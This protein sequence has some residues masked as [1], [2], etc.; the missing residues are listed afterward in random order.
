MSNDRRV[1]P[2]WFPSVSGCV[3]CFGEKGRGVKGVML[4][5]FAASA[6]V[7]FAAS[8]PQQGAGGVLGMVAVSRPRCL[9]PPAPGEVGTGCIQQ[10]L[11]GC[12][13]GCG[14]DS[15]LSPL[16]LCCASPGTS[17]RHRPLEST[18]HPVLHPSAAMPWSRRCI[19][20]WSS[21]PGS[22]WKDSPSPWLLNGSPKAAFA[23]EPG[24][25][26]WAGG[27]LMHSSSP[28]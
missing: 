27:D 22:C 25:S 13:G 14:T 26:A 1:F 9:Q 17:W 20:T 23:E 7:L 12:S 5:P 19:S 8:L 28:V 11:G 4:G 6:R 21:S 3:F 24:V 18:A 16:G 2:A 10:V 15:L